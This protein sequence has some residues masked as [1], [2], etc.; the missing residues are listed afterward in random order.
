LNVA[1]AT[2]T[3]GIHG[4]FSNFRVGSKLATQRA[5][6]ITINGAHKIIKYHVPRFYA[7]FYE[8]WNFAFITGNLDFPNLLYPKLLIPQVLNAKNVDYLYNRVLALWMSINFYLLAS[9]N[10]KPVVKIEGK[11]K[12]AHLW[13]DINEAYVQYMQDTNQIVV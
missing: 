1:E 2:A 4:Y 5:S 7:Q 13:G 6:N 9:L 8:T 11:E 3:D 12:L 10:Q